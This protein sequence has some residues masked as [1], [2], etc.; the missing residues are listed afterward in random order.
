MMMMMHVG[1]IHAVDSPTRHLHAKF[2]KMLVACSIKAGAEVWNSLVREIIV[3]S[4][5]KSVATC[6]TKSRH[7]VEVT[8]QVIFFAQDMFHFKFT[9]TMIINISPKICANKFLPPTR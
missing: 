2:L 3:S 8:C 4:T 9:H 6:D 7:Q 5:S 1:D